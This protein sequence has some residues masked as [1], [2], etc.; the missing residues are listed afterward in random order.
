MNKFLNGI[1]P[2]SFS[3]VIFA[4]E[5]ISRSVVLVNGPSGCKFYHS[6]TS[7]NQSIHSPVFDP[8]ESPDEFFFGQPR[9]PCTYLDSNDY[10]YGSADKLEC[11][12]R[13][14]GEKVP[15]DLLC[16]V[17]SPGAAL[18]GDNLKLIV[19]KTLPNAVCIC[20]ESPGFSLDITEGYEAA[21]IALLDGLDLAPPA[22]AAK[23]SVNILGLSILHRYFRGDAGEL[24]RLLGL[25]GIEVN[26]VLGADCGMDEVRAMPEAG[27]N[28][29]IHP[30][31][32][33]KTGL[34]LKEHCGTPL[35]V[36]DGPPVGFSATQDFVERICAHFDADA[37]AFTEEMYRARAKA[38]VHISRVNS[39][40]GLPKGTPVA[41]EGTPCDIAAYADFLARYF[42]MVVTCAL[43]LGE[44]TGAE[45]A[46]LE[47]KLR[48]LN[49][50]DALYT[51][52]TESDAE[53]VFAGGNTIAVLK[54]QGLIFCGIETALPS[55]GYI[56]VLDKTHLGLQ[57][58]LLITEQVLN[59]LMF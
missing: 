52:I 53:L 12:L 1:T 3:G 37:T 20:I 25:C 24:R 31:Y 58:A 30:E 56:D 49:M 10:V 59:G 26:C 50:E 28:V 43:P 4:I 48:E 38:Y 32:G 22:K 57:G 27:L 41:I 2:D 23:K 6:A 45:L 29:V 7:D 44:P 13:L 11:A 15:N 55:L 40:T 8:L 51:D 54:N 42:G 16:V 14:V 21:M 35:I 46:P 33:Q 18:I 34:W 47:A 9:I 17:N 36:F 5:G 19:Q 39:L